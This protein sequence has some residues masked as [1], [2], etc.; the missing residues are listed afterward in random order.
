[1]FLFKKSKSKHLRLGGKGEAIARKEVA[2]MGMTFLAQNYTVH[3]IG[4]I[5]LVARDGACLVFIEVKTRRSKKYGRAG[6]AVDPQKR[7]KLRKTASYYMKGLSNKSLRFRFDVVE[8]YFKNS[9]SYEV[10]YLVNSF[11]I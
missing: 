6:E 4:E 1:M 3:G 10:E 2:R 9:F 11:S 5:D 8:V 7:E